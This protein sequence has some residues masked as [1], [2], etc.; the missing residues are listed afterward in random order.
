MFV[1]IRKRPCSTYCCNYYRSTPKF[2]SISN[3]YNI[4]TVVFYWFARVYTC[5]SAGGHLLPVRVLYCTYV[6]VTYHSYPYCMYLS[7]GTRTRVPVPA[8]PPG[9]WCPGTRSP[10]WSRTAGTFWTPPTRGEG[11][12][13]AGGLKTTGL[14]EPRPMGLFCIFSF[15]GVD[16]DIL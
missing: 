10:R 6:P 15:S 16:S 11:G 5:H 1:K 12:P 2:T 13:H 8:S 4:D 7:L 3:F 9:R 14:V